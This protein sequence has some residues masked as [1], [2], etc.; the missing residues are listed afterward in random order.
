MKIDPADMFASGF[1]WTIRQTFLWFAG[2]WVGCFVSALSLLVGVVVDGNGSAAS[3]VLRWLWVSPFLLGSFWLFPNMAILAVS[4]IYFFRS[5][6]FGYRS[7]GIFAALESLMAL[8][9]WVNDFKSW[10]AVG[11]TWATWLVLTVMIG[12]ALWFIHQWQRNKWAGEIAMLHAE[13]E[14]RKAELRA[15]GIATFDRDPD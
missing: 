4:V 6:H 7:W 5:D 1:G 8:F 9:G 12:T 10:G 2:I 3:H 15:R 11:A 13:N 14:M